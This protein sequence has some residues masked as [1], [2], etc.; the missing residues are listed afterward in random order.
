MIPNLDHLASLKDDP[1]AF[2]LERGQI[3]KDYIMSLPEDKRKRVY[4][5]QLK[6]DLA[7]LTLSSEELLVWMAREAREM[8]ANLE[9][10]FVF[11]GNKAT[12]LQKICQKS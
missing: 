3:I 1:V 7:R 2:E 8:A 12:D 4:A 11:I 5:Y 9:D 6:I 10:Q